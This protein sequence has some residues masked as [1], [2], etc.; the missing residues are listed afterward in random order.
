[1]AVYD[2]PNSLTVGYDVV[3][4]RRPRLPRAGRADRLFGV[5]C[6]DEL[7][8]ELNIDPLRMREINGGDGG[9]PTH[10]VTWSIRLSEDAGSGQGE[11]AFAGPARPNQ[12]G[13]LGYWHNAGGDR[14]RPAM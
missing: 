1:M 14:A 4:N 9:K 7:A 6:I 3:S 13:R 2:F 11:R 5:S 10:G 12:R 8:H